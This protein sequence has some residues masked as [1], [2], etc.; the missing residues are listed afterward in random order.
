[1]TTPNNFEE[2]LKQYKESNPEVSKKQPLNITRA[3]LIGVLVLLSILMAGYVLTPTKTKAEVNPTAQLEQSIQEQE[4]LIKE[5][6]KTKQVAELRKQ[7]TEL[8]LQALTMESND[9]N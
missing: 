6:E 8:E 3:I 4:K 7:A 5:A 1:M 2:L 9:S